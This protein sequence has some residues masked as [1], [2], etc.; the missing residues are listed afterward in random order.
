[1]LWLHAKSVVAVEVSCQCSAVPNGLIQLIRGLPSK[2]VT[3][4]SSCYRDEV[5][6]QSAHEMN[7]IHGG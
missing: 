3:N 4:Y 5:E 7:T 1:M 2:R 6:E